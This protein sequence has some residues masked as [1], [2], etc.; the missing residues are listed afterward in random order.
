MSLFRGARK[1]NPKLY[2]KKLSYKDS[3]KHTHK[4]NSYEEG[5]ALTDIKTY[6]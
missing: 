2:M 3:L 6:W 4:K 1:V 5:V